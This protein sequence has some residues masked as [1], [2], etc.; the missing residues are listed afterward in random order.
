TFNTRLRQAVAAAETKLRQAFAREQEQIRKAALEAERA[1]LMSD[2]HDG[3]AGHLVSITALCE[4][5]KG[6]PGDEIARASRRALTD[7]RLVVDSLEDMGDDLAV[8]LTALRERI[9][10]QL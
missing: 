4:Q 2:L 1:R 8:M 6:G 10:P 3:I 5:G 9:E 7:L